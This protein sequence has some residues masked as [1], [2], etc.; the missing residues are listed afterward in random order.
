MIAAFPLAILALLML[1]LLS[2]AARRRPSQIEI[3]T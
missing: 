1:G 3:A 2:V